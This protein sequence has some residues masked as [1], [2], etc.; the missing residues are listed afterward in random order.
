M[1]VTEPCKQ[2]FELGLGGGGLSSSQNTDPAKPPSA[3]QS[4]EKTQA[5]INQSARACH[6]LLLFSSS[7]C[8]DP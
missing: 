2:L 8:H 3:V 1:P 5:V 4:G 6:A 7:L